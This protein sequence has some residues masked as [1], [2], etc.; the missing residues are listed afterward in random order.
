M[1]QTAPAPAACPP[2]A[3]DQKPQEIQA[4]IANTLDLEAKLK[5]TAADFK[6]KRE[7]LEITFVTALAKEVSIACVPLGLDTSKAYKEFKTADDAIGVK[8]R[9]RDEAFAVVE[10]RLE[11]FK[12]AQP[13]AVRSLLQC[14]RDALYAEVKD[15]DAEL[16]DLDAEL[17]KLDAHAARSKGS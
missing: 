3:P 15:L 2:P 14:R 16:K 11:R 9:A 17:K 5:A 6:A 13:A 8:V 1:I 12:E 7:A 4:D 10:R